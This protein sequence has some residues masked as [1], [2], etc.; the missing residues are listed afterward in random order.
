MFK[1]NYANVF[2]GN[3]GSVNV[4][5]TVVPEGGTTGDPLATPD[6]LATLDPTLGVGAGKVATFAP[7]AKVTRLQLALMLVRAGGDSLQDVPA[8]YVFPFKDVPAYAKAAVGIAHYNGLLSGRT[9]T[10]FDPYASATRGQVAK[11]VHGLVEVLAK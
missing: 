10:E 8:G 1:H 11:M 9:A 2:G 5:G 4:I 7:E 3:P 6:P